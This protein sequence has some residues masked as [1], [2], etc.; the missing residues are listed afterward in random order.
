MA[1][2]TSSVLASPEVITLQEPQSLEP[3]AIRN[4]LGTY[5]TGV[6]IVTTR[7]PDGRPVGL[8]INSFASVSLSPPIVLWSLAN[9]SSSLDIFKHCSHFAIHFLAAQ[10]DGLASRFASSAVN[11]KFLGVE[12]TDA[13][14][15]V[16]LLNSAMATLLCK[17]GESLIAGDHLVM[18]GEVTNVWSKPADP[19]VFHRGR[20]IGLADPTY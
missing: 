10:D 2:D 6:A 19:L 14:E 3:R 4:V 11:D 18:F 16:P 13:E 15:G 9:S 17:Q 12:C 8:T 7:A 20:L 5:P 1:P